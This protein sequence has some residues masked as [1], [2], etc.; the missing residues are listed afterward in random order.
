MSWA[1]YSDTR[2]QAAA[3]RLVSGVW[4]IHVS[5]ILGV[6]ASRRRSLVGLQ[7]SVEIGYRNR[8]AAMSIKYRIIP[9]SVEGT[10]PMAPPKAIEFHNDGDN[11]VCPYCG[12][13]QV[14]SDER[15]HKS[16]S[17]IQAEKWCDGDP[18]YMM[19][20]IVCANDAC[21][22]LSLELCLVTIGP[23]NPIRRDYDVTGIKG[24]WRLLPATFAK[25]QPE[26]I[27]EVIRRDYEEACA[28]R[29][30]SPKAS[31]TI[32]RR[33]IQGVIRD[34][35]GIS[36]GRLIDE[37]KELRK[38]V[39]E[40][41]APAGV[42]PDTVDAIDHVRKIG[43]IGAHMEADIDVIVDVDPDEAQVLI[44]LTE[45]LFDEWYVA[46]EQR[47]ARLRRLGFIASEKKMLQEQKKLPP[48]D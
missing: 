48:P 9:V 17:A 26:F 33:C 24:Y 31:A 2:A 13:P 4:V 6:V 29:D 1:S 7:I 16:L 5:G 20:A 43:N 37:I 22:R 10:N 45:M 11:W 18:G 23:Y 27:P 12:M 25:P 36:K 46:R 8:A 47:A 3:S 15:L 19:Q 21:R 32:T 38:Q 39:D 30:L 40:G 14:V 35:C 34:F 28:I 41:G 42:Q 44:Q